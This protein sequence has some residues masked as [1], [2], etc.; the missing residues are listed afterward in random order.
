VDLPDTRYARS[1]ELAIAYQ[2]LGDGGPDVALDVWWFNH[3]DAQWDFP[4]IARLL[5]RFATFSRVIVFDKRGLGLSDPVQLSE[6]P[7]SSD[8][9]MTSTPS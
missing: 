5:R 7:P 6:L 4:P 3:V 2:V 8:G 9:W 1:G